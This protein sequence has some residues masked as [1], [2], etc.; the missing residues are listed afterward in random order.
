[1]SSEELAMYRLVLFNES[2]LYCISLR[3]SEEYTQESYK[4]LLIFEA[5]ENQCFFFFK[6]NFFILCYDIIVLWHI[7]LFSTEA[8]LV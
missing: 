6:F 8:L 1:M 5:G 7:L 4:F 2:I 3:N